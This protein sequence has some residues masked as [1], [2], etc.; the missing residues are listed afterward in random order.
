[1]LSKRRKYSGYFEKVV[2]ETLYYKQIFPQTLD[3]YQNVSFGH[4]T[5]IHKHLFP[6]VAVQVQKFSGGIVSQN[7]VSLS[8]PVQ[9]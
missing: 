6:S 1:M 8:P 2:M 4:G 5:D 3:M 7:C 9:Y